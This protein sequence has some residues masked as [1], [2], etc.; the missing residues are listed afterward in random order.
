[1]GNF[2]LI[3]AFY[4]NLFTESGFILKEKIPRY[5]GNT[6]NFYL[7]PHKRFS[8]ENSVLQTSKRQGV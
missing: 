6:Q 3:N 7:P 4:G 1:M 5:T 8:E 2:M